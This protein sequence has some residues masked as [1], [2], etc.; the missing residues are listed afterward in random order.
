MPTFRTAAATAALSMMLAGPA[1][2]QL[3]NSTAPPPPKAQDDAITSQDQTDDT[4]VQKVG[5]ALRH[6]SVI[7]QK[8]SQRADSAESPQQRQ[9]L[10][11]QARRDMMQAIRDQGL[12]VQEYDQT[13]RK[14]QSDQGLRRRLMA[15][16]Q[17]AD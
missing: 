1:L 9:D 14:A 3:G 12:S 11:D 2:A 8:Y 16:A 13:V 6:V 15:A 17:A 7:R 4:T 5:T 10:T